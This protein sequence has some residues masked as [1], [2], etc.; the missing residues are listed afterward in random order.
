MLRVGQKMYK[1]HVTSYVQTLTYTHAVAIIYVTGPEKTGLMYTSFK[2][3]NSSWLHN[4]LTHISSCM[5][6]ILKNLHVATEL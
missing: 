2:F 5:Q 1:L 6:K 4:I 3:N